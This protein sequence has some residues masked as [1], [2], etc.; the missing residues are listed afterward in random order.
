MIF[1]AVGVIGAIVGVLAAGYVVCQAN[2]HFRHQPIERAVFD[3]RSSRVQVFSD[4]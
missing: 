4:R 3:Y 2:S 1:S